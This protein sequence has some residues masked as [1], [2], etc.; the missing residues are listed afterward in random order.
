MLGQFY[1]VLYTTLLANSPRDTYNMISHT[2]LEDFGDYWKITI[3]GPSM[4][5]SGFY[6]YANAVNNN[7]QR[8]PKEVR[9]YEWVERTIRQVSEAVG[10]VVNYE[11]S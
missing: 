1:Y 2:V 5:A 4:S 3:S 10:G 6:D 8:G 11:L 9:N 7:L